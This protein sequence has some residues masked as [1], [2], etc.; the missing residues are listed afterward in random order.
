[1]HSYMTLS[2]PVTGI[3]GGQRRI[4]DFVFEKKFHVGPVGALPAF[5]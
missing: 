1:M 5:V 2:C 4:Q 3:V